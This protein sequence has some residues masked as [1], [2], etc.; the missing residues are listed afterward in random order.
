MFFASLISTYI[1]VQP[2]SFPSNDNFMLEVISKDSC[3]KKSYAHSYMHTP[4]FSLNVEDYFHSP[5]VWVSPMTC[6][7]Q[8]DMVRMIQALRGLLAS[9][10][11]LLESSYR[12]VRK[13]VLTTGERKATLRPHNCSTDSQDQLL[14]MGMRSSWTSAS[15]V[16]SQAQ[17]NN[18]TQSHMGRT[19]QLS[20][21]KHRIMKKNKNKSKHCLN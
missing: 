8:Q 6:F 12:D 17:M 1:V 13:Q 14:A 10:F 3:K 20:P 16:L 18:S 15:A 2:S 11:I 7:D 19:M 21:A 4:L 5:R 9:A